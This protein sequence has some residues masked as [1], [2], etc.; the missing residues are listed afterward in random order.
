MTA[1]ARS[2]AF[3]RRKL[4]VLGYAPRKTFFFEE[5]VFCF[6]M[7]VAHGCILFPSFRK[8]LPVCACGS[9]MC[10]LKSLLLGLLRGLAWSLGRF[11]TPGADSTVCRPASAFDVDS[12][13]QCGADVVR[14][15]GD[16][17]RPDPCL[18]WFWVCLSPAACKTWVCLLVGESFFWLGWDH[19]AKA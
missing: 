10:F 18:C 2:F 14:L 3:R 4:C 7:R 6:G 11:Q 15:R 12:V 13:C 17:R 19:Q 1:T 16:Q 5:F 8:L 9:F